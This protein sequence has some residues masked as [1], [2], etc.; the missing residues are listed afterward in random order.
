MMFGVLILGAILF[1]VFG[2]ARERERGSSCQS[3]LK[4]VSLAT[5]MYSQDYDGRLPLGASWMDATLTYH[6]DDRVY[7]C[8]SIRASGPGSYGYAYNPVFAGADVEKLGRDIRPMIF[9]SSN[10]TRNAVDAGTSVP[11]RHPGP[12]GRGGHVAHLDGQVTFMLSTESP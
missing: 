4:Q 1:P 9:D 10:T 7:R 2:Q 5:L 11:P 6:A 3:N 8:P 12:G